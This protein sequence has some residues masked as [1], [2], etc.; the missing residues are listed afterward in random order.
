MDGCRY[1]SNCPLVGPGTI[2][3]VPSVVVFLRDPSL[4]FTW[5]SEKTTDNSDRLGRQARPGFE[6]GTSRLPVLSVTTVPLVGP[7]T[8]EIIL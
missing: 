5:V 8:Y 6:P 3:G 1:E 2:G 4:V 7:E